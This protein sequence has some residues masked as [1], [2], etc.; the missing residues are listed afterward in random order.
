MDMETSIFSRIFQLKPKDNMY[1]SVKK[2]TKVLKSSNTFKKYTLEKLLVK[3]EKPDEELSWGK[4][5]GK[6]IW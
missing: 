2:G 6:E 3:V 4:P 1:C 5:E